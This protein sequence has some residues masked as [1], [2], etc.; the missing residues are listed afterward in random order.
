MCAIPPMARSGTLPLVAL[1]LASFWCGTPFPAMAQRANQTAALPTPQ[2]RVS[3]STNMPLAAA[4][5]LVLQNIFALHVSKDWAA[6]EQAA[7]QLSDR[8]LEGHILADRWLSPGAPRPD[9]AA[10]RDWLARFGDH[11]NAP[12]IHALLRRTPLF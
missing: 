10:L 2:L 11:P 12:D 6:A 5:K 8:R 9:Q 3:A 1:V 7:A 4:D